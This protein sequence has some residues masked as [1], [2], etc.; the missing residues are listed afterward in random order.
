M[1]SNPTLTEILDFHRAA[2]ASRDKNHLAHELE[3][4]SR[5]YVELLCVVKG[6]LPAMA[7]RQPIMAKL[8]IS[9]LEALGESP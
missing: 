6:A 4:V 5:A 1:S 8:L 7:E 2:C 3:E 9:K